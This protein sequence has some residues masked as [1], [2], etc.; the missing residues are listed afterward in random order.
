MRLLHFAVDTKAGIKQISL[1]KAF[2]KKSQESIESTENQ[3]GKS[4]LKI[5]ELGRRLLRDFKQC[6]TTTRMRA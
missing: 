1:I 2:V 6:R 3:C 4:S 5:L